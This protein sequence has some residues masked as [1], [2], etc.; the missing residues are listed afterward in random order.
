MRLIFC[1]MF[2]KYEMKG[3]NAEKPCLLRMQRAFIWFSK[4][5]DGIKEFWRFSWYE[6][7]SFAQHIRILLTIVVW[8]CTCSPK[9][10]SKYDCVN[11]NW[12]FPRWLLINRL[13]RQFRYDIICIRVFS[14]FFGMVACAT[15]HV[16]I[17]LF[18]KLNFNKNDLEQRLN[19]QHRTN[20]RILRRQRKNR[21]TNQETEE[22]LYV[23]SAHLNCINRYIYNK[24]NWINRS[25]L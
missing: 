10:A 15:K 7:D 19:E 17:W 13:V 14:V 5:F 2:I 11:V 8:S 21:S 23:W 20:R 18:E 25:I 1:I 12:F 16:I 24:Y 4:R 3:K 6:T 9:I 22:R